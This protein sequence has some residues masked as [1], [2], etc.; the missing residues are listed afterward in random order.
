M[1]FSFPLDLEQ[2]FDGLR[3]QVG[4][5]DLGEAMTA[6]E[7]GGGEIL[8]AQR[9]T[10]LWAGTI[11]TPPAKARQQAAIRAKLSIL[12]RAGSSFMVADTAMRLP[13]ADPTGIILA[14]AT[15]VV[16]ALTSNWREL[17][18]GGLPDG[19]AITAGDHLSIAFGAGGARRAY[20][21][22]VTGAVVSGGSAGTIEVSPPI[23]NSVETG[24][25]VQLLNPALKA[26]YRPNSYGG[27]QRQKGQM[28]TGLSFSWIQTLG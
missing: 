19:Y 1:A 3:I 14:S 24:D 17:S 16:S 11:S 25:A 12:R 28:A 21:E 4:D 18:I 2:F 23:P 10:A 6:A 27:S 26:V 9:G 5:F 13:Q 8:T 20:F 22:V 15:P 7:T